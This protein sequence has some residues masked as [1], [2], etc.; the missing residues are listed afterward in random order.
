MIRLDDCSTYPASAVELLI[1]NEQMLVNWAAREIE[2]DQRLEPDS[3]ESILR[4]NHWSDQ[5]RLLLE[6][7]LSQSVKNHDLEVLHYTRLLNSEREDILKDGLQP[8]SMSF[9]EARLTHAVREGFLNEDDKQLLLSRSPVAAQ[10]QRIGEVCFV[11]SPL[12]HRNSGIA[13][14]LEHWGGEMTYFWL[15]DGELKQRLRSIGRPSVVNARIRIDSDLL[16]FK[17]SSA[18]VNRF[19]DSR[20]EYREPFSPEVHYRRPVPGERVLQVFNED[21]PEF[22]CFE[23]GEWP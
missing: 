17:I 18:V 15:K 10:K 12:A 6:G 23:R 22:L 16:A 13:P 4:E 19:L 5:K 1:K 20:S 2:L 14:L 7:P 3:L 21:L 9:L 11:T 8:T